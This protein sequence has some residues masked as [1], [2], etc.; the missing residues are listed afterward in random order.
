MKSSPAGTEHTSGRLKTI[1]GAA[2]VRAIYYCY[3]YFALYFVRSRIRPRL[4]VVNHAYAK[5][6]RQRGGGADDVH[7]VNIVIMT[8]FHN[9]ITSCPSDTL[10]RR[11]VLLAVSF[12]PARPLSTPSLS[13]T[14]G[15]G[16]INLG[17]RPEIRL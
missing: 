10:S 13:L 15:G 12:R 16:V 1:F 17:E 2:Y 3:Y 9:D 6:R 14:E 11:V 7:Y 5:T 8:F 4:T